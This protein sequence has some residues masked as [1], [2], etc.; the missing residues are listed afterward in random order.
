MSNRAHKGSCFRGARRT[1]QRKAGEEPKRIALATALTEAGHFR[2]PQSALRFSMDE[3]L[4]LVHVTPPEKPPG[5][6]RIFD[7]IRKPVPPV[8]RKPSR[9]ADRKWFQVPC[10][11]CQGNRVTATGKMCR[12]CLGAGGVQKALAV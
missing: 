1:M 3:L 10:Q 7:P 9:A 11:A 4:R 8:R 6:P 2:H 5:T 12:S